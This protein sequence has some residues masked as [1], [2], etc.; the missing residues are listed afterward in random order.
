MK[1]EQ[2]KRL[3]EL[4]VDNDL[5]ELNITD[6]ETKVSLKRGAGGAPGITTVLP[7]AEAA[8]TPPAGEAPEAESAEDLIEIRSPMVGTFYVS[9]SPD[10]DQFISVGDQVGGESVVCIIEAMKVMNEIKADCDGTVVEI[11]VSN[12]QPVEFGQV[13]FRVRPR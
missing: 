7:P 10:T 11:C 1:I 5:S 12:A 9:P 2:I 4:M 3:V 6:G 13:L 8:P